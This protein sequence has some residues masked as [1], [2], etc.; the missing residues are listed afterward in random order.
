MLLPN[1]MPSSMKDKFV[2]TY[3]GYPTA[4]FTTSIEYNNFTL[5]LKELGASF[6]T[7]INK[8]KK[9]GREF[10]VMLVAPS[11]STNGD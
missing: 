2:R 10:F 8:N 9:R 6:R 4:V 11:E 1:P 7:K 5:A 3:E